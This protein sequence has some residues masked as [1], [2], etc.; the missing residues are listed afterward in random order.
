MR[1][2]VRTREDGVYVGR[3]RER[4]CDGEMKKL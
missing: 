1:P 4:K 2:W 3:P